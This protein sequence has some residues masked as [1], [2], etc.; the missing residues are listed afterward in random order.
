MKSY[1]TPISPLYHSYIQL[2]LPSFPIVAPIANPC[3]RGTS[4]RGQKKP[5]GPSPPP[6]SVG[7]SATRPSHRAIRGHEYGYSRAFIA[8]KRRD[9]TGS[10]RIHGRRVKDMS[11]SFMFIRGIR[12]YLTY[13]GHKLKL[14][15][16]C[17]PNKLGPLRASAKASGR[18]DIPIHHHHITP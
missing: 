17:R 6:L 11:H 18:S 10:L 1:I 5:S 16:F 4:G 12:Q 15:I 3:S 8:S 14:G 13:K 2:F 9:A 7:G